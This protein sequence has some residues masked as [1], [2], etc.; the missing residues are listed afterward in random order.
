MDACIGELMAVARADTY[1]RVEQ[2][3]NFFLQSLDGF[4]K[5]QFGWMSQGGFETRTHT[6][7][8]PPR[9]LPLTRTHACSLA[10]HP[11]THLWHQPFKDPPRHAEQGSESSK[12]RGDREKFRSAC[13]NVCTRMRAQS[14]NFFPLG[15]WGRL[16][17]AVK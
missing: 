6:H 13:E 11:H 2:K 1:F 12:Q 17:L 9:P 14:G 16:A 4:L 10:T 7:T 5:R 8:L 3:G 15:M